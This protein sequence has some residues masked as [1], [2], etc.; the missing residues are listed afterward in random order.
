M[1]GII[2][3]IKSKIAN[4]ILQKKFKSNYRRREMVNLSLAENMGI[5]CKIRNES[6]FKKLN[7]LVKEM[8]NNKRKVLLLGF[9]DEPSIPDYC[10]VAGPGYYFS[11]QD[12][13]RLKIPKND[14]ILKFI[15]KEMDILMDL[16]RN[17]EFT[18]NYIIAL[19]KAKLKV[20]QQSDTK[21]PFLDIMIKMD[22]KSSLDEFILQ[23]LHYLTVFKN[24]QN[25]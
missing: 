6:E 8:S 5:V 24:K 15:D 7:A 20:G 16:T 9:V 10:V 23:V 19:S 21:E 3:Q 18:T 25:G 2:E 12:L 14:Y 1:A 22:N 17:D 13:N 4:F 11:Q